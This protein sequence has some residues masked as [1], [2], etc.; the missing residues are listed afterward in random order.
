[1]HD[2]WR[3]CYFSIACDYSVK[4]TTKE[5]FVRYASP[6]ACHQPLRSP[7]RLRSSTLGLR[8][9]PLG[10]FDFGPLS[11]FSVGV[12]E[13]DRASREMRQKSFEVISDKYVNNK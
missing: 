13:N 4:M 11:F 8:H 10:A 3:Q 12:V 7:A 2:K 6:P 5:S 1:M 9:V